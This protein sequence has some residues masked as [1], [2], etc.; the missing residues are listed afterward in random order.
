MNKELKE[1]IEQL[2]QEELDNLMWE[3]AWENTWKKKEVEI[4]SSVSHSQLIEETSTATPKIQQDFASEEV[5][6]TETKKQRIER[7]YNKLARQADY[8]NIEEF[9]VKKRREMAMKKELT[10][11]DE[12]MMKFLATIRDDL[13]YGSW[14]KEYFMTNNIPVLSAKEATMR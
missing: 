1:E 14:S 13:W 12:Y 2:T 4:P 7:E 8:E 3:E 5:V 11:A 10:K 6:E 9:Y